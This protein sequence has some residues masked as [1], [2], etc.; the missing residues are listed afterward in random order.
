MRYEGLGRGKALRVWRTSVQ[1][2]RTVTFKM[3]GREYDAI[4]Q[5][6]NRESRWARLGRA[7]HQVVPFK[8]VSTNRFVAVRVDGRVIEEAIAATVGEPLK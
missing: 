4:E 6:P 3:N 1:H 5:N 8:D 7:G 2:F